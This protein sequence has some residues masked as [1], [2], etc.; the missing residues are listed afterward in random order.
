[1]KKIKHLLLTLPQ[2]N[3]ADM[4]AIKRKIGGY[5][6]SITIAMIFASLSDEHIEILRADMERITKG[7]KTFF[8]ADKLIKQTEKH[9]Q[10]GKIK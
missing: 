4:S 9:K 7:E 10:G 2:K 6:W 1:M 3:Y 5:S 8:E